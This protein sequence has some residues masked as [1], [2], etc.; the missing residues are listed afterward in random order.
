[1]EQRFAWPHYWQRDAKR[2]PPPMQNEIDLSG[3]R[4]AFANRLI[5]K[6][7]LC[8]TLMDEQ[9]L[10]RRKPTKANA[11]PMRLNLKANDVPMRLK[12][13]VSDAPMRLKNVM[14]AV[15][16]DPATAFQERVYHV[17]GCR[18][19]AFKIRIFDSHS[20]G[21]RIKNLLN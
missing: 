18:A 11:A 19:T 9:Y 2:T 5:A 6:Q 20:L 4:S 3:T 8:A 14:I 13:P 1:M 7:K 15:A 12:K 16:S 17:T 10:V 21:W